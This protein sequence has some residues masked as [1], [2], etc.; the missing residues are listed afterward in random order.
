MDAIAEEVRLLARCH[1]DTGEQLSS[2]KE[3]LEKRISAVTAERKSLYKS[4][5]TV[6]VKTDEGKLAKVKE[7]IAARTAELKKLRKEVRLC[8][9]IAA[10][11][12]VMLEKLRVIREEEKAKEKEETKRDEQ[13]RRRGGT[14]R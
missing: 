13:F 1:I 3:S 14:G 6:A 11:S 9:D 5:R 8:D 10:R 7:E 2:Y 4:Q 12:G